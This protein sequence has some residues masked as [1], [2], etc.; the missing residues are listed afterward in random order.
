M[1]E[2]RKSTASSA[3]PHG[4]LLLVNFR[5]PAF[6]ALSRPSPLMLDVRKSASRPLPSDWL[7]RARRP[8]R[9]RRSLAGLI[10][11]SHAAER[12]AR[13]YSR[14]R[15]K[16]G[17]RPTTG[18]PPHMAL[19]GVIW[20]SAQIGLHEKRRAHYRWAIFQRI[21]EKPF[22]FPACQ[23]EAAVQVPSLAPFLNVELVLPGRSAVDSFP[24]GF[25]PLQRIFYAPNGDRAA[26]GV[27]C[28]FSQTA[29]VNCKLLKPELR[30]VSQIFCFQQQLFRAFGHCE[31][32]LSSDGL[33]WA[34]VDG[35]DAT[36]G[37]SPANCAR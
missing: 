19:H 32:S 3:S 18:R 4:K 25:K 20:R 1:A 37:H 10:V 2:P 9:V 30:S 6:S 29:C 34:L 11:C 21:I 14:E 5:Q 12:A 15:E 22:Y 13:H 31:V 17:G 16:K 36:G 7:R 26:L 27:S 23:Q 35:R 33:C 24:V 28:S 8:S